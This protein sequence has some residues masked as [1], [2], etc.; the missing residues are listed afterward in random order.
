[1]DREQTSETPAPQADDTSI[2]L[3]RAIASSNCE[4]TRRF[5]GRILSKIEQA[6]PA[7]TACGITPPGTQP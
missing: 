5:L 7:H 1:M 2:Y 4:L 3:E 6:G